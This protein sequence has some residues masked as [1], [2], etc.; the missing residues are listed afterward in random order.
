L[1][2]VEIKTAKTPL[3]GTSYRSGV[4]PPS[5]ELW[6]SI[7]QLLDQRYHLQTEIA[8]L[9]HNSG[10]SDLESYAIKGVIIAGTM[11]TN[12]AEKKSLELFRNSLNDL[13]VI[14]FD[15]LVGKLRGL[16]AFL[17]RPNKDGAA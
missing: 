15:E 8:M 7:T 13:L 1:A 16:H 5:R 11:P 17:A 14:T 10:R 4:Y 9:R 2:L 3:L 12:Q 6:G